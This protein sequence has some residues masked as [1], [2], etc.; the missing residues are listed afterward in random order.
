MLSF[1]PAPIRGTL[2]L[3]TFG[4]NTVFWGTLMLLVTLAKLVI[5]VAPWRRACS[6]LLIEIG[7]IWI[8]GNN[9]VLWFNTRI[10]WR[11]NGL[12]GLDPKGRFLICSNHQSAVDIVVLQKIF[13]RRI[14]FLKFFLKKELIW[15]PVLGLCWWAL[16]FPFMKRFSKA[17][18]QKHPELRGKDLETTKKICQRFEAQPMSIINFFEGTRFNPQTH[19][20]Q[21]SPY[22]H[23][24]RPKAGGL[25]FVLE[26]MGSS[27]SS[28]L[29][30]TIIYHDGPAKLMDLFYGDIRTIE[31]RVEQL[32]VPQQL[33]H[34]SYMEDEAFRDKVQGW[35]NQRWQLKDSFMAKSQ[36]SAPQE[37]QQ[38]Q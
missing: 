24:L 18:I 6:R 26:V 8:S 38:S 17:V 12:E 35:V 25:A 10:Q 30:V 34:G 31:V 21:Q 13:N 3:L 33:L 27:L 5:P 7:Q 36:D 4:F 32:T 20:R 9:F 19:A 16:D 28:L 2:A 29:D 23:L 1:L 14:P 15:V 22:R 37:S 11:V